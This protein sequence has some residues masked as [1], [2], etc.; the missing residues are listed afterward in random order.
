MLPLFPLASEMVKY[1][2]GD[3]GVPVTGANGET[4]YPLVPIAIGVY[5]TAFNIFNTILLFPFISVFDRVLSRV[6]A[7][8]VDDVED[9]AQPKFLDPRHDGALTTGLPAIRSETARYLAASALFL[10][11]ARNPKRVPGAADE[12]A[13]A[14]DILNRE[15]RRYTAAMFTPGL[16][17]ARAD[18]LASLI[19]EEDFTASLGQTLHQIARRAE[20]ET[21]S[22]PGRDLVDATVDQVAAAM[23]LIAPG[24]TAGAQPAASLEANQPVLL[25]LREKCLRLGEEL[26]WGERGAI[27]AILGSAERAFFLIDR[28]DAER[29][30]VSREAPA[31]RPAA[32]PSS[33]AM[34]GAPIPAPAE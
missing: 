27:L 22:L 23:A 26:P 32:E 1:F 16:P 18:L 5:S 24:A 25:A 34:G 33:P 21:F 14:T 17:Y 3:P 8:A 28:I 4:T 15:I 12:H 11:M 20:R 30:S 13:V 19:E 29:R 31:E 10:D 9:Y 2:I 6:G 7:N